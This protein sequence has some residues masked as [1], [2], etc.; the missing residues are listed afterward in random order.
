MIQGYI[1]NSILNNMNTRNKSISQS[2]NK[3]ASGL[4][5]SKAK[6][7]AAGLAISESMRAQIRCLDQAQRNI[8]DGIS[9]VQVTE[10]AL[11]EIQNITQRMRELSVQSANG[12][13]T[14]EDRKKIQVEVSVLIDE[15]DSLTKD[16]DF[17]G[18][19][20]LQGEELY[21]IINETVEGEMPLWV[22]MPTQ[23]STPIGNEHA[24]AEID[25]SALTSSNINDLLNQ[26]FY[27]TCCTCSEKYSIK[28]VDTDQ[29][30]TGSPNPVII[31]NINGVT[32]G[33]EL[34][35]RIIAQSSRYLNHFT[36][37][38]KDISNPDKLIIYDNRPGQNPDPPNGY[39]IVKKGYVKTEV[40]TTD[41]DI[42]I[43][44]GPNSGNKTGIKL[45]R[46]NIDYMKVDSVNV[47]TI[48]SSKQSI[49]MIDTC[50]EYLN[51]ER[52]R[53]GVYNNTLDIQ[54]NITVNTQENLSSA[55][56]KIKD[57][58]VAKEVISLSKNKILEQASISV[59]SMLKDSL[60]QS[61]K[62]LL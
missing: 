42:F 5:I 30:S 7:D 52:T 41:P 45:P 36:Q 6:D 21:E 3:L 25:F 33:E 1:G 20:V 58:N 11:E 15:I 13:I 43:Q 35:D 47:R 49:V 17:N 37:F 55:E 46:T 54:K 57:C 29:A 27:S 10:G 18:V 4:R 19:K 44:S 38:D 16:T 23:L 60:Q 40:K 39:G 2:S 24:K 26:G 9:L 50:I 53:M 28:F 59:I 62:V 61:V 32:T 14:N 31:V 56:S 8:Q 51:K 12:S 34:V 22:G 48:E